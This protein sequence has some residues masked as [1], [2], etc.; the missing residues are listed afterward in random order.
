MWKDWNPVLID[1]DFARIAALHANVVRIVLQVS[2]FGFP[3][4]LP[5]MQSRLA[6][7][8]SMA[9]R[10]HLRVQLT[11]FDWWSDYADIEGSKQWVRA[12]LQGHAADRR[13]AFIELQNEIDATNEAAMRWARDLI[14]YT[15]HIARGIPISLSVSGGGDVSML[16]RLK[17]ELASASP[18]LY[19]LHYYGAAALA[20]VT[21]QEARTLVAPVPLMNGETGYSTTPDNHA[22]TG[23]PA[24]SAAQDA[25]QD[26]YYRTVE[27][28]AEAAGLHAV[29][30]WTLNDFAPHAIPPGGTARDPRQYGF[31]LYRANGSPK[32]AAGTMRSVFAGKMIDT[33]FNNG[34]ETAAG[35]LPANWLEAHPADAGFARDP[36]VAHSGKASARLSNSSG[37]AHGVP[38]FYLSP[39]TNVV[40]QR[41]YRAAVWARGLRATGDNRL[42]LAWFDAS[43]TYLGQN[44]SSFLPSGTTPWTR[45]SVTGAAPAGAVSV[46]IHLKSSHNQGIVWF[47][48]VTFD[49]G[50]R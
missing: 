32:P 20:Y 21:F 8:L 27:Y 30:V 16:R 28:A 17:Q 35:G 7:M 23:L 9:D 2:A 45:L 10:H 19:D 34:F 25:Y 47:D 22:I 33:T 42:A 40:P 48:D 38:S 11:L 26:Q 37:N 6:H 12:I 15:R 46:Q 13:I 41:V 50:A 4:P 5:E 44:E 29:G 3:T 31:G 43:N 1:R 39:V 49:G 18:D 14:P 36:A 24:N